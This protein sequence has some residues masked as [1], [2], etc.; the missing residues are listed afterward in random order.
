MIGDGL[1]HSKFVPR[2][3]IELIGCSMI[4][5]HTNLTW[6]SIDKNFDVP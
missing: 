4:A 2:S 3:D 1:L 6:C 5:M